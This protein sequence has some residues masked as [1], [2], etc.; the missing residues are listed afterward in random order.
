MS[1]TFLRLLGFGM[2]GLG[3][4]GVF[5]P[6]LPTTPFVLLSAACFA[7]SSDKWY[8]WLLASDGFGPIIRDWER[9]RCIPCRIKVVAISMMIIVG[10][11]SMFFVVEDD[12]IRLIGSGFL[13]LGLV[14]VS[15]IKTCR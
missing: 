2:L 8:Q 12:I 11:F 1:K 3:I 9:D 7:R 13:I 15:V 6:L 14:T 4:L 5:L 10:G